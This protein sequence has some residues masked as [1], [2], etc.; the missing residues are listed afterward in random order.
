MLIDLAIKSS[1]QNDPPFKISLEYL[2]QNG[3]TNT[4]F[5]ISHRNTIYEIVKASMTEKVIIN[6]AAILHNV[7][8]FQY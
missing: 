5:K 1:E 2:N 6:H 4:A 7:H 8:I 3:E